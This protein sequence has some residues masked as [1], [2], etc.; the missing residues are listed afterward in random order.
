MGNGKY[1]Y[2]AWDAHR[3]RSCVCDPGWEG[4][5][6]NSRMCPRGNDPLTT[7][8]KSGL[9]EVYDVQTVVVGRTNTKD[10]GD[11]SGFFTLTFT[12]SYGM[13]WETR[14][15]PASDHDDALPATLKSFTVGASTEYREHVTS[16]ARTTQ[17]YIR[18]ALKALPNHAIDDV[19]VSWAGASNV[20][21]YR[22]T[23]TSA[24]NAGRRNLLK[25]NY[26]GCDE[27]GCQPRY[28]GIQSAGTARCSVRGQTF[29]NIDG[30]ED[31]GASNGMATS[32]SDGR[33]GTGED[34]ECSNR[35]LCDGET[36]LCACFPGY[37]GEACSI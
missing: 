30:F 23:F 17:H 18:D 31:A 16:G 27:D 14:P 11:T 36:G 37:T 28:M 25:C 29:Y 24:A 8:D 13:E 6:C 12:D 9:T 19:E 20:N 15:I 1:Q 2:N 26:V 34:A 33:F 4:F 32:A 7:E 10:A 21:E 3:S 35:G 22:V 5:D